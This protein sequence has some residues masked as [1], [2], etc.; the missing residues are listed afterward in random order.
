VRPLGWIGLPFIVAGGLRIAYD[1]TLYTLFRQ[2][3]PTEPPVI[4]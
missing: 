4:D 1:L 2:A 3:R